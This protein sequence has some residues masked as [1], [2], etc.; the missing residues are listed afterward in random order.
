MVVVPIGTAKDESHECVPAAATGGD[1]FE[2][3]ELVHSS[4]ERRGIVK[5][6]ICS[7]EIA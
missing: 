4:Q 1:D 6:T 5:S 3:G 7:C 2:D